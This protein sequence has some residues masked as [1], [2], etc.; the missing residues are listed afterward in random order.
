MK[1]SSQLKSQ[2]EWLSAFG[3]PTRVA[4]VRALAS[5]ERCVTELAKLVGVEIPNAS[6][7]LKVMREVGLV[8]G[9]RNGRF[10]LYSLLGATAT[11]TEIVLTHESGVMVTLPLHSEKPVPSGK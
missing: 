2:A 7:H 1:P 3:E 9:K 11:A 10:V 5:G 8:E 4:I 6:I